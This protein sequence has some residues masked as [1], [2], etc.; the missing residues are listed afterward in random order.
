MKPETLET[1][2]DLDP[3]TPAIAVDEVITYPFAINA[4]GFK[5]IVLSQKVE[6]KYC[7]WADEDSTGYEML[8]NGRGEMLDLKSTISEFEAI[9]ANLKSKL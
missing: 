8:M 5:H 4:F 6:I 1:Q 3:T 2:H 9:L 7:E